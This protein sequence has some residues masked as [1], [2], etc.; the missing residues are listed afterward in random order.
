MAYANEHGTFFNRD[1]LIA[2]IELLADS[3]EE[4]VLEH[5]DFFSY[6]AQAQVDAF[7]LL[8]HMLKGEYEA[9]EAFVPVALWHKVEPAMKH[10]TKE[11]RGEV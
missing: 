1:E 4:Y 9:M 7:T 11:I 6:K 2:F 3:R 10:L 8:A 5:P